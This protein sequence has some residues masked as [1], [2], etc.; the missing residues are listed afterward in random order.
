M[1]NESD[2]PTS[3]AESHD[4]ERLQ[5][6]AAAEQV[7]AR[8]GWWGFKLGSVLRQARLSTRSF[9][10]HF[11]GKDDL[12]SA[13]L[14][15]E[16]LAIAEYLTLLGENASCPVEKVRLYIE[17]LIDLAFDQRIIKP[18]SMFAVH[19]RKL[20][21]E[22][23]AIVQRC[24]DALTAPL[25]DALDEGRRAG[26][27]VC[28]DPA[29][30]ATAIFFLISSTV[31]DRPNVP[32]QDFRQTAERAIL[33]FIARALKV[34]LSQ[35]VSRRPLPARPDEQEADGVAVEFT[36]ARYAWDVAGCAS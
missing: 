2:Q 21:P 31:F 13:L 18:A 4:T 6:M 33:P 30:E 34:D 29:A 17:A 35:P 16:L 3:A 25:A 1:P 27:L 11:D 8:G 15:G 32:E 5:L 26:V 24:S 9:Y 36:L 19:W 28:A 14:E 7:L 12:L 10:R 22:H 20:L 23:G